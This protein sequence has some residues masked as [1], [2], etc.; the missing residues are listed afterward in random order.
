[1][2]TLAGIKTQSW[3]F[4]FFRGILILGFL[5]LFAR[6]IELMVIKGGYFRALAEGNRIRRIPIEAP[7]GK[8]LARGGEVLVGNREVKKRIVFT[9][10]GGYEKTD[11][12]EG[13][14]EDDIVT[15]YERD[16][17]LGEKFAHISGYLGEVNQQEVGKINPACPERGPRQAGSLVGRAG[18]EEEYDC[19]LAG[20]DG[21]EL[22][23]VD[24]RGKRIRTLGRREPIPGSDIKTFIHIG[25]Q[26]KVVD[27]LDGKKGAVIV[28]EPNGKVMA[29]Y[30]SPSF[31]PAIFSERKDSVKISETLT[32]VNLP[33]FN[34]AI[35]GLFHPGSVF[36]PIV[37][38]AV[39]AEEKID[40]NFVFDDP[41]VITIGDRF[42]YGNW[43]YLQYGKTE[44]KINIIKA[45]AR[46]T[47]TFFYK[48]GEYLGIGKI[49]EW[50]NRFGLNEKT[51][52]DIPGEIS[53]L[54][55]TPE[56]K[57]KVKKEPW[58]LG[59]TY[60][61]SIGQGDLAVTPIEINRAISAIA[62]GGNLC[63]PK[64]A[65]EEGRCIDL[66]IKKDY[67]E[68]IKEGM[69]GACSPG[70][71]GFTF[72]DFTPRVACKTGTAETNE[73]GKTHAWFVV[74][75]PAD[76]PEIVATVLVEGGGEGSKVA[77]PIAREIFD[78]WF[79]R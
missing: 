73:D 16:Y 18:L 23:E 15:E 49:V 6:L 59:N 64:I 69:I 10:E 19:Q 58:F 76:F 46:S 24:T 31:D 5:I 14:S 25:L 56:W 48:I 41:G 60:H 13:A 68:L 28:T 67:L 61:V 55:P 70:G 43:Y 45:I 44:G 72:F 29:L 65:Y 47:D 17:P 9:P 57:E 63:R 8:I 7:R 4:W 38:I 27:A 53:G 33:L 42:S 62:F 75:G 11:D 30:S 12:L 50:A 21:E 34:R 74:F 79:K 26:N 37:A 20:V 2:E 35:G 22:V 54:V 78:Y 39:L 51:G 71:T 52:I 1:M 3:L 77:G 66:K 36:K 32:D 40:K